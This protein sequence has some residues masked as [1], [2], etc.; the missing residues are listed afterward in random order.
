[1]RGAIVALHVLSVALFWLYFR[2]EEPQFP[3]WVALFPGATFGLLFSGILTFW[4]RRKGGSLRLEWSPRGKLLLT[5]DRIA[6]PI[7]WADFKYP[8]RYGAALLQD[9]SNHR[10]VLLLTQ[11]TEPALVI[12]QGTEELS[13]HW[14]KRALQVDSSALPISSESAGAVELAQHE[15]LSPL[16]TTIE[17]DAEASLWLRVALPSGQLLLLDEHRL[18]LGDREIAADGT[19]KARKITMTTSDGAVVGLSITNDTISMLF[20]STDTM[21]GTSSANVDAP[22]AYL[23]PAVFAVLCAKFQAQS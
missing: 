20:A 14:K 17:S 19:A 8:E 11:S 23:H 3:R 13:L 16:L 18:V 6:E 2:R 7:D 15:K 12:D 5:G 9:P 22:D 1:L 21:T 4:A 10:R